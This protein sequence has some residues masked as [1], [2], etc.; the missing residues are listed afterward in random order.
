MFIFFWICVFQYHSYLDSSKHVF[1]A[2]IFVAY[3]KSPIGNGIW[4]S[5]G[6][7]A[8]KSLS[9]IMINNSL[10]KKHK[11]PI[12]S[13]QPILKSHITCSKV[14][15][16]RNLTQ[17]SYL[18]LVWF[19]LWM[20]IVSLK[21]IKWLLTCNDDGT[22]VCVT[23]T[24]FYIQWKLFVNSNNAYSIIIPTTAHLLKRSDMCRS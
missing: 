21:G 12:S 22:C 8:T 9:N 20:T 3:N 2:P 14:R 7:L 10:H 6:L 1:C 24:G 11:T 5:L 15:K 17:S 23:G 4:L 16:I 18:F 13:L 19:S